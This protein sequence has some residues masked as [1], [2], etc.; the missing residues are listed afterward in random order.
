MKTSLPVLCL[1]LVMI[2]SPLA[3][4]NW[5]GGIN[6]TG[7]FPQGDLRD[8]DFDE[9]IGAGIYAL[10]RFRQSPWYA[11][12]DVAF[13]NY[14]DRHFDGPFE[15]CCGFDFDELTIKNNINQFHATL[16]WQPEQT[17]FRPYAEA[18]AGVTDF[19]TTSTLGDDFEDDF[20]LTDR[21][22]SDTTFSGGLGAGLLYSVWDNANGPGIALELGVRYLVG[23]EAWYVLEESVSFDGSTIYF[24]ETRSETDMV[25]AHLGIH[26][27]F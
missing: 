21:E 15:A 18:L 12:L 27:R 9:G 14:G 7:S 23:N 11:G 16:R 3:A 17:P 4:Q 1:G 19:V 6:L 10:R 20:D 24:E 8:N 13:I 26:F 5:L 25:T 22:T 2:C